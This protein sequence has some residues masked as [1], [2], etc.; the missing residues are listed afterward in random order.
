MLCVSLVTRGPV[1]IAPVRVMDTDLSITSTRIRNQ[2]SCGNFAPI[3]SVGKRS[4]NAEWENRCVPRQDNQSTCCSS[5]ANK[6]YF[7][8]SNERTF[9][10]STWSFSPELVGNGDGG[11]EI[12]SIEDSLPNRSNRDR[13][14]FRNVFHRLVSIS[15]DC[16]TLLSAKK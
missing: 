9:V 1:V 13:P 16:R 4:E 11:R 15:S 10:C 5:K 12:E 7:V 2:H 6:R 14:S 3:V 8:L